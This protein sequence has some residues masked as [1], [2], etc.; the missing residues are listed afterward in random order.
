MGIGIPYTSKKEV[1]K[2]FNRMSNTKSFFGSGVGLSIVENILKKLNG[3][4]DFESTVGEGT[5]F[6]TPFH[7]SSYTF[8]FEGSIQVVNRV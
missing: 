7:Q 3:S 1:F 6:I 4:V 5:Q 8:K 2:I